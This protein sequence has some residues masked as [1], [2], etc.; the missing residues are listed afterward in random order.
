MND[1]T[2]GSW[3]E[4]MWSKKGLVMAFVWR[5]WKTMKTSLRV[6]STPAMIQTKHLLKYRQLN[7]CQ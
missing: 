6:A 4:W 1:E 7:F 3:K 2:E 5:Y